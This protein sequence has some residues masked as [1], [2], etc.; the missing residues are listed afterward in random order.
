LV[1]VFNNS[2]VFW[3]ILAAIVLGFSG[4]FAKMAI[5]SG[6]S[7][8]GVGIMSGLGIVMCVG[9]WS[10]SATIYPN[11]NSVIWAALG[12]IFGGLGFRWTYKAFT[13]PGGYVSVV[14]AISAA[15]P[16]ITT[17][18]GLTF[19]G[20]HEFLILWRIIIGTVLIATGVF[21]TATSTGGF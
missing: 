7:Y 6:A 14:I 16:L 9:L 4:P 2:A 20:E 3:S 17:I 18:I 10:G 11:L 13:L 15:Y 8:L 5:N 12:G 19:M 21:F 1:H